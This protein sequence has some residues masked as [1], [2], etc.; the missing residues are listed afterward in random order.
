MIMINTHTATPGV[1]NTVEPARVQGLA[2]FVH[3]QLWL[4]LLLR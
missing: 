3:R 1:S 4:L 2:A